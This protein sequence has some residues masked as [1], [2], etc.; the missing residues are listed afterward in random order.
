MGAHYSGRFAPCLALYH[1]K[2]RNHHPTI[3]ARAPTLPPSLKISPSRLPQAATQTQAHG[4][5][6]R[7]Q[8]LC[9]HAQLRRQPEVRAKQKLRAGSTLLSGALRA[10]HRPSGQP[11]TELPLLRSPSAAVPL[12]R[13]HR[14]SGRNH[15]GHS[16]GAC[17]PRSKRLGLIRTA[18]AAQ[19][20]GRILGACFLRSRCLALNIP[21]RLPNT[22]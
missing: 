6:G 7:A 9:H 15:T 22:S 3:P 4:P 11:R 2:S 21:P 14:Y 17:F 1:K 19:P 10:L 5:Q 16:P 20:R 18:P 13:Q 8:A 12:P